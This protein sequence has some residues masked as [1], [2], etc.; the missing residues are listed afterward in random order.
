MEY[1]HGNIQLE[2]EKGVGTTVSIQIPFKLGKSIENKN[3]RHQQ[4]SL[5][6]LCVLV[7]ED[8]DLNMEIVEYMLERNG[9]RVVCAKDGQEVIDLGLT[10]TLVI[11]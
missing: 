11:C 1:M 4:I 7:A 6:G 8:N 3:N 10:D 9:I 2:S 5:E